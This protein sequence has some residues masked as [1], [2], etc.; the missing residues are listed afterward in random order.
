MK[1][2]K[3]IEGKINPQIN[4]RYFPK[5]T[6]ALTITTPQTYTKANAKKVSKTQ[7]L[8]VFCNKNHWDN[9]CQTYPSIEQR[10]QRLKENNACLNCLQPGH[11]TID[12]KSKK[13]VCFHYKDDHNTALY[14]AK[15]N[16]PAQSVELTKATSSTMVIKPV[17]EHSR[18]NNRETLLFCKEVEVINL[19]M[20]EAS[21]K[22][23]VLFNSGAQVTCISKKL[24]K[25]LNQEDI[26]HEQVKSATFGNRRPQQS[27]TAKV[28]IG[29]KTIEADI[30]TY[31]FYLTNTIAG[32]MIAG[33]GYMDKHSNRLN[34]M[35]YDPYEMRLILGFIGIQDQPNLH[36]DKQALERFKEN[37]TK[38]NGRYQNNERLL[39]KYDETIRD[40][41][42]SN[43][44]EK[45]CP[46]MDHVGIIH[47]LPHHEVITPNKATTELRTVY[48]ASSHQKGRKELNDVLYRGPIILLD[49]VGVLL[50]F[51]MMEIVII[52]DIEKA[53][54]QLELL[55]SERNCTRFLWLKNIRGQTTED[56]IEYNRFQ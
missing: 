1:E 20:Q 21:N 28:R 56:N 19:D 55:P 25:R 33:S 30:I 26:D 41:I 10:M 5:E 39:L 40:Q 36:E 6:S 48:D 38:N 47:Y 15:Y 2:Q 37:I 54:L 14:Y 43:V 13:R 49:L 50:R 44:I 4:L 17:I 3:S 9:E 32:P 42:Q 11:A 51:R 23:V 31:G 52:V 18:R 8:C 27:I 12:C 53:F 45:V 29:I 46:E 7:R 16:D 34:E 22:V 24:A 35:I